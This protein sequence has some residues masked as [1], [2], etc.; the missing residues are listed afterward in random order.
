MEKFNPP[1]RITR[2]DREFAV[3][4]PRFLMIKSI[5]HAKGTLISKYKITYYKKR[6]KIEAYSI[7]QATT[8]AFEYVDTSINSLIRN[9]YQDALIRFKERNG[10]SYS[11]NMISEHVESKIIY[12][13]RG[14]PSN[15]RLTDDLIRKQ[16]TDE[17]P[18][19]ETTK[20]REELEAQSEF[21]DK[22]TL[23][24]KLLRKKGMRKEEYEELQRTLRGDDEE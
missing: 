4:H 17:K 13:E 23:R 11:T 21:E 22:K 7:G 2:R 14:T 16:I 8:T 5:K 18:V 10:I 6:R 20:T 12:Y 9:A 19:Y 24:D 3:N 1:P 15:K